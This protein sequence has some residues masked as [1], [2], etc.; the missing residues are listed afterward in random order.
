M[1]YGIVLLQ[2]HIIDEALQSLKDDGSHLEK[3]IGSLAFVWA[4]WNLE[5]EDKF[6]QNEVLLIMSTLIYNTITLLD[7]HRNNR[8]LS[9]AQ[10]NVFYNTCE[11]FLLLLIAVEWPNSWK[12]PLM[13]RIH[14]L[15]PKLNQQA[16]KT[17]KEDEQSNRI[18]KF[19]SESAEARKETILQHPMTQG[20][21]ADKLEN[22]EHPDPG[23]EFFNR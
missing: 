16:G 11:Y 6:R 23:N 13:T 7:K 19:Q 18:V 12:N 22:C 14:G 10:L 5:A 15:F 4:R 3:S 17:S 8:T 20:P 21:G 1:G 2:A 9:E